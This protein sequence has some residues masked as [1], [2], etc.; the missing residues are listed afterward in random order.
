L[1]ILGGGPPEQKN[2]EQHIRKGGMSV[3]PDF[4]REWQMKQ[5]YE[6]LGYIRILAQLFGGVNSIRR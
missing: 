6:I 3:T 1:F 4:T 5:P 2:G